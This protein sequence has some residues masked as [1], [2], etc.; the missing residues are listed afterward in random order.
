MK[1]PLNERTAKMIPSYKQSFAERGGITPIDPLEFHFFHLARYW[2]RL[3]GFCRMNNTPEAVVNSDLGACV[4][5]GSDFANDLI[6]ADSP[7]YLQW[8]EYWKKTQS[9]LHERP[10]TLADVES[11]SKLFDECLAVLKFDPWANFKTS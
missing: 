3:A 8:Q 10:V 2:S 11:G 1:R 6:G 5:F 9:I 7:I 4:Q